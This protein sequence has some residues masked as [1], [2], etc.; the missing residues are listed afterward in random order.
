MN[1]KYFGLIVEIIFTICG[2]IIFAN[3]FTDALMRVPVFKD[4]PL[5]QF[6][7]EIT[8]TLVFFGGV[9]GFLIGNF[10]FRHFTA[11]VTNLKNIPAED[12]IAW[13][14]GTVMSMLPAFMLA[15]LAMSLGLGPSITV[16]LIFIESALVIW[17][18]N[19][20]AMSMKDQLKYLVRGTDQGRG[21]STSE[22]AA[23]GNAY[24]L[25]DASVI[26]DGRIYDVIRCGFLD[27]QFFV[28]SFVVKEIQYIAES[29]DP[30]RR[31]RGR[32][33]LDFLRKMQDELYPTLEIL[34]QSKTTFA[35]GEAVYTKM[36]KLAKEI[37]NTVIITCDHNLLKIAKPYVTVLNINE[38][39]AALKPAL[40]PGEELTVTI[41]REGKEANEGVGYLADGSMV[42]IRNGL[43]KMDE[44][45][46][47][48]VVSVTHTAAGKMIFTELK[49][50]THLP[51][52]A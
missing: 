10:L 3:G 35:P 26:I 41:I 32:R 16:A 36:V 1:S 46:V 18:G 39:A 8:G 50:E 27:G 12:K 43:K 6:P 20:I 25:L 19:A 29:A 23:S 51:R 15:I 45:V 30:L 7:T 28:P 4:F 33:G 11:I 40:L 42:V 47:V 38:L 24:K 37:G 14:V 48:S 9:C 44:Q 17:I 5:E 52:P 13:M 49:E 31:N 2:A 21:K 22:S 34:D